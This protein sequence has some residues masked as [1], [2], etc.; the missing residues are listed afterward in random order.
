MKKTMFLL[1]LLN[2]FFAQSSIE[3]KEFFFYKDVDNY[4]I[5]F[6]TL[7]PNFEGLYEVNL[8]SSI[9]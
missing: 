3:T 1:I 6:N 8:S 5:D 4:T 2:I 7:I 9:I